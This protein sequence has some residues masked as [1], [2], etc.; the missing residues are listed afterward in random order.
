ML[1]AMRH[2]AAELGSACTY[3]RSET[4]RAGLAEVAGP[5]EVIQPTSWAAL[6][7]VDRL[8][9]ERDDRPAAGAG[10]QRRAGPSS[11]PG[12]TGGAGS[13]C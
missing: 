4:Y 3:V 13:G 11:P 7:L 2:R 6:H 10:L 12:P 1:S 8:A 5:L 9:G